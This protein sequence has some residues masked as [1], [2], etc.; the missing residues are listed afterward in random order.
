MLGKLRSAFE[1]KKREGE[2]SNTL[3]LVDPGWVD[4]LKGYAATWH[5]TLRFCTHGV[6]LYVLYRTGPLRIVSYSVR[7]IF[8]C[9]ADPSLMNI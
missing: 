6:V 9:S 5:L 1:R 3:H 8:C 4:A 2:K 7:K